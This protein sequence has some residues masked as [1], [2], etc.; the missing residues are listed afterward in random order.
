MGQ[1]KVVCCG[2][3]G[4]GNGGDEALL[5]SLLQML[6]KNCTPCVISGNPQQT[7]QR[8][9]VTAVGRT[10]APQVW[11]A[12]RQADAFIWGGGS[13]I[14]D[15][16]SIRSP[17]Y[18]AGLMG[19]AQQLGLKTIALAQGIGPLRRSLTRTVAR[20]VFAGCTAVSVRDS[21]S[22]QLLADWNIP[23]VMAPD[24]VWALEAK[25]VP[26]AG[27]FPA[28]RVAVTLREHPEL[29]PARLKAFEQ[30]LVNFQKATNTLILLV[31][32]QAS[33][34]L[35]IAQQLAAALEDKA[36][37]LTVE[38]PQELKGLFLG[39]EMA[40]GM[41]LHSVI[42]AAAAGCKCFCISYDP[43]VTQ[44]MTE[45]D[46]P[47]I[48]VSEFPED[49]DIISKTLLDCYANSQP[50]SAAKIQS[51]VDRSLMHQDMLRQVLGAK[52]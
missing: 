17:L 27:D 40:V 39:V 10:A 33:K 48:M 3:Y 43:K 49:S 46:L 24:L 36:R 22:A 29:T 38:D 13:L 31:P 50:M 51:L 15:A 45:L 16:T 4:Q 52:A 41:R 18:Y 11:Q 30:A 14:Q 37:I 26:S 25:P 44:L 1:I 7:Q 32:F 8:Y 23:F 5:A 2:Y 21:G 9:K 6:P 28:P 47:G 20:R 42:M 19:L 12:L 34:D 35:A